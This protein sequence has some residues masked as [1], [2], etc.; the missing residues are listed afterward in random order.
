MNQIKKGMMFFVLIVLALFVVSCSPSAEKGAL[1]GQAVV[2]TVTPEM[3][4]NGIALNGG[5][6]PG[7]TVNYQSNQITWPQFL[8][9]LTV[10]QGFATVIGDLEFISAVSNVPSYQYYL[11]PSATAQGKGLFVQISKLG[12]KFKKQVLPLKTLKGGAQY[13]IYFKKDVVWFYPKKTCIPGPTAD[14]KCVKGG[15]YG[16]LVYS[17]QGQQAADCGVSFNQTPKTSTD[18]N[19]TGL[20]K[21][22]GWNA[23]SCM[24][25]KG[26]CKEVYSGA[27]A[28]NG[29]GY[30]NKTINSCTGVVKD[31]DSYNKECTVG[32][33]S[34]NPAGVSPVCATKT[35]GGTSK[36]SKVSCYVPCTP[37][38]SLTTCDKVSGS[39][40]YTFTCNSDGLDYTQNWPKPS[41]CPTGTTCD[42]KKGLCV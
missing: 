2:F 10:E 33:V 1:A 20:I 37:G 16:D 8:D 38:V 25:G 21:F 19:T 12:N 42:K 29:N 11:S 23:S 5:L 18:A 24:D 26:C 41:S 7:S 27:E 28:C 3:L 15:I 4:Q 22:C 32:S 30:S 35:Y 36:V 31:A 13:K 39:V 9:G 17:V 34:N 6:K 14:L 40:S